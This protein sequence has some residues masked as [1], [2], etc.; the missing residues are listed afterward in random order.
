MRYRLSGTKDRPID[1]L[2]VDSDDTL[3]SSSTTP[4]KPDPDFVINLEEDEED[5]E[6]PYSEPHE[7]DPDDDSE[8]FIVVTEAE[9]QDGQARSAQRSTSSEVP[10]DH[11]KVQSATIGNGDEIAVGMNAEFHDGDFLRVLHMYKHNF[12][13]AVLLKG[14]LLRRFRT[15]RFFP[16]TVNE[17]VAVMQTDAGAAEPMIGTSLVCRSA[18][19]VYRI[20]DVAITNHP[21]ISHPNKNHPEHF[22]SFSFRAPAN[23]AGCYDANGKVKMKFVQE[24]A[25]LVC[26]WKLVEY[27]NFKKKS[28]LQRD[29]KQLRESES[30]PGKGMADHLKRQR[31]LND[32]GR[33]D[34]SPGLKRYHDDAIEVSSDDEP[35]QVT[36]RVRKTFI[37]D[38][39][40][41]TKN[42]S[43]HSRRRESVSIETSKST[44]KPGSSTG[45]PLFRSPP[46]RA[47]PPSVTKVWT[48]GDV[49]AGPGG[50]ALGAHLSGLSVKFLLDRDAG[51]CQT[52]RRNWK[53]DFVVELDIF[54]FVADVRAGKLSLN[55]D[56][57]HLSLP[58]KFWAPCH[59][60]AGKNDVEN[61]AVLFAVQDLLEVCKPRVVTFEQ[62]S[63]LRSHHP[64]YFGAFLRIITSLNYS[65]TEKV[66]NCAEYGNVQP[67][68]RLCIIASCPGQRTPS[69][70]K[71][72]HGTGPGLKPFVT[73]ADCL[74]KVRLPLEPHMR[75][76]TDKSDA[77]H[78]PYD[79]NGQ[80]K[81]CI[82]CSGGQGD[83]HPNAMRSFNMQELAILQ[84]FLPRYL[85]APLAMTL[86]R[87]QIGNACPAE[88][89]AKAIFGSVKK[90][91]D[92]TE[93]ED[94][95][96]GGLS[97]RYAIEID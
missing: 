31:Y 48:Y 83:L 42:G 56:V 39:F 63:G 70:P 95:R 55:V 86:V 38:T 75:A 40:R 27:W 60:R 25:V 69:L 16:R 6:I 14:I 47:D 17:L 49:C 93:L 43:L 54:T 66:L 1:L 7:N 45:Y 76:Y 84:G 37:T 35:E 59:T 13:Q 9:W 30:D 78:A 96:R 68:M 52:L 28:I 85:F 20:R 71:P 90:T 64:V 92:E 67:R 46:P 88:S 15:A 11:V 33:A 65:L 77:G 91:L 62:T 61:R 81:H 18:S 94:Q 53:R 80:M 97:A 19:E 50:M 44:S 5:D 74:R 12:T 87:E 32:H 8:D 58:C 36:K 4:V 73:I 82:T 26:R 57:L 34:N 72:T 24:T 79:P 3:D 41:Q 10:K 2:D 29:F 21:L 89:L 22:D 23:R 51:C